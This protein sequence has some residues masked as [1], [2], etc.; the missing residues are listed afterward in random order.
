MQG[1]Y[2]PYPTNVPD[3]KRV[4]QALMQ[5][6]QEPPGAPEEWD[7]PQGEAGGFPQGQVPNPFKGFTPGPPPQPSMTS[8]LNAGMEAHAGDSS[9]LSAVGGALQRTDNGPMHPD[10]DAVRAF[11]QPRRL[12]QLLAM[13]MSDEEALLMMHTGGA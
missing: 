5:D 2:Q 11:A 7:A 3:P 13:G 8:R 12:A 9:L 6:E 10:E 4:G 1:G